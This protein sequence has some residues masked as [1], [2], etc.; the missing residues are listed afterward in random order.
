MGEVR[1]TSSR[2]RLLASAEEGFAELYGLGVGEAEDGLGVAG[3]LGCGESAVGP[4][5]A[6]ASSRE[7]A[8]KSVAWTL[9]LAV[10]NVPAHPIVFW[11]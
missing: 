8:A 1:V 2:S 11:W 6:R 7:W 4:V 10:A 5:V 9:R 3:T